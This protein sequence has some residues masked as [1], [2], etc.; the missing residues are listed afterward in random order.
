MQLICPL[1]D[2]GCPVSVQGDK[3]FS[4]AAAQVA[5]TKPQPCVPKLR[6]VQQCNLPI[7]QPRK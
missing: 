1:D 5:H 3:D 6:P 7:H 4:P 2:S